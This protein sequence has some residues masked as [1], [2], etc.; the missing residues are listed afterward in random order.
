MK[1][2]VDK[3]MEVQAT[4]SFDYELRLQELIEL[5]L[6]D[7]LNDFC[8][9]TELT[10]IV[11]LEVLCDRIYYEIKEGQLNDIIGDYIDDGTYKEYAASIPDFLEITTIG[12]DMYDYFEPYIPIDM[13]VSI[14][15]NVIHS[16][17]VFSISGGV[18]Q[19]EPQRSCW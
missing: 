3:F 11:N 15:M 12:G 14:F 6:R 18:I 19:N 8:E 17:R 2:T 5:F 1:M 10:E 9:Q 13:F 4:D 7:A 16:K